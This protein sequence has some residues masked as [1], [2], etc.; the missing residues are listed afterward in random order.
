M[1]SAAIVLPGPAIRTAATIEVARFDMRIATRFAEWTAARLAGGTIL[2]GLLAG[3]L[4]ASLGAERAD[5]A[6]CAW[7]SRGCA[8]EATAAPTA[9][10]AAALVGCA[11]VCFVSAAAS[12]ARTF[13][14]LRPAIAAS[15]T[16]ATRKNSGS[17]AGAVRAAI[18]IH[19]NSFGSALSESFLFV[20]LSARRLLNRR[21][22][23]LACI[24]FVSALSAVLASAGKVPSAGGWAQFL[25]K[26]VVAGFADLEELRGN[27]TGE[28]QRL[29][30]VEIDAFFPRVER[31]DRDHDV[32]APGAA[33]T[34]L[35]VVGGQCEMQEAAAAS[36]QSVARRAIRVAGGN[37]DE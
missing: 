33:A 27:L 11:R 15:L 8:L 6:R 5:F 30:V 36:T 28:E 12:A 32:V 37:A 1:I 34:F 26:A 3:S 22:A 20:G 16:C 35:G 21:C 25:L 29:A 13:A 2:R 10:C 17:C 7:R 24:A 14:L 18:T 23:R 31:V 9:L 19:L 4:G